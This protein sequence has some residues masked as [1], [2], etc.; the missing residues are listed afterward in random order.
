MQS[1]MSRFLTSLHHSIF[2]LAELD[3]IVKPFIISLRYP[4]SAN[5]CIIAEIAVNHS[6][7]MIF[8]LLIKYTSILPF[9]S[10]EKYKQYLR[11]ASTA[12]Q[13]KNF[14]RAFNI[15]KTQ[16][17]CPKIRLETHSELAMSDAQT[18]VSN[19]R[20]V[21]FELHRDQAC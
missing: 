15:S 10:C 13:G 17:L 14:Y 2:T 7:S 12:F 11:S 1:R 21:P 9:R 5:Y 3:R 8:R 20:W 18:A 4:I 19:M 16:T 6:R